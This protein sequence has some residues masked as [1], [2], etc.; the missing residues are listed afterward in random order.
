MASARSALP[1]LAFCVLAAAAFWRQPS[2]SLGLDRDGLSQGTTRFVTIS[3]YTRRMFCALGI[4]SAHNSNNSDDH[5]YGEQTLLEKE[6]DVDCAAGSVV[7][8]NLERGCTPRQLFG[9][10]YV[11]EHHSH[12]NSSTGDDG[13]DDGGG[14]AMSIRSKSQDCCASDVEIDCGPCETQARVLQAANADGDIVTRCDGNSLEELPPAID[15]D[16]PSTTATPDP[17]VDITQPR[18]YR[19]APIGQKTSGNRH[20]H[21]NSFDSDMTMALWPSPLSPSSSPCAE[22]LDL[23]T[24]Q[25]YGNG[26]CVDGGGDGSGFSLFTSDIFC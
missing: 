26:R 24:A 5:A 17:V 25:S 1:L 2:R 10:H 22:A 13:D 15:N 12:C 14:G 20:A 16:D 23:W 18:M 21:S 6:E 4:S 9:E 8:T 3:K 11:Q 19:P 7:S